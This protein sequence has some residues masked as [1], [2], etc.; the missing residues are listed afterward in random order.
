ML[1]KCGIICCRARPRSS[2]RGVTDWRAWHDPY[3]DA[4]SDLS[5][6][7]HIVQRLIHDLVDDAPAGPVRLLSICAGQGHDVVAA[8]GGHHRRRD[9]SGLLV[10]LDEGN[11]SAAQAALDRAGLTGL[12]A[13]VGDA[14]VTTPYA[15]AV[16]ADVVLACGVFGNISDRDV[17]RTVLALPKLCAA[18]ASVIWTRHRREPDLTPDIRAW[19]VGAGFDEAAFL[20][21]GPNR[22]SVGVHQLVRSGQP[23]EPGLPLFSFVR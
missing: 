22:F 12:R 19:F 3:K 21:P 16:P 11:V 1:D 8:L 17:R 10:E 15:S 9:V 5:R 18:G 13:E 14:G 6:R 23:Y 2:L 7:L 4:S 20:S